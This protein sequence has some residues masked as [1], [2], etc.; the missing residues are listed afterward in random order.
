MLDSGTDFRLYGRVGEDINNTVDADSQLY[1]AFFEKQEALT[2]L[3]L[4]LGRHFVTSSAGASIVDG[5]SLKY[6]NLGPMTFSLFGGGDVEYYS[7]Y[8]A[9]DVIW[10]AE[11][12]G[13]FLNDDLDLG[14]SYIQKWNEGRLAGEIIGGEFDYEL[15]KMLN[16]YGEAQ[17]NYLADTFSYYLGGFNYYRDPRWSWRAEYLYSLPVFEATSIYSVFAVNAYKEAMTEVLY[18]INNKGLRSFARYT[19]EF[20]KEFDDAYIG[21]LGFEKIRYDRFA[22]YL[23]FLYRKDDSGQDMEGVKAHASYRFVNSL[24]LGVGAHVDVLERRLE[25]NDDE[26]TSQRYWVDSTL[27]LRDNVDVQAKVEGIK[28]DLYSEYFRGR[29]RLNIRF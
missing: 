18:R 29:V 23:S 1:Y 12:E 15:Q 13:K 25:D 5:I 6:K 28:S 7:G 8:D 10:G 21:E 24:I 20:Y 14:L 4:K 19:M 11:T 3:D 26:T 17:F 27:P 9:Q 22:G 2:N 16:L